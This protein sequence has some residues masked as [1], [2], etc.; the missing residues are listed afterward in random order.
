M[1]MH[2]KSLQQ[3]LRGIARIN[4]Y[5][6]YVLLCGCVHSIRLQ[7]PPQYQ[8]EHVNNGNIIATIPKDGSLEKTLFDL[9]CGT[10]HLCKVFDHGRVFEVL[11]NNRH[12]IIQDSLSVSDLPEVIGCRVKFICIIDQNQNMVI[13][14][15]RK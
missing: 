1:A 8:Q 6:G 14:M 10:K 13:T 2:T 7:L 12:A 15:K 11:I 4:V 3:V 9:D 5:L